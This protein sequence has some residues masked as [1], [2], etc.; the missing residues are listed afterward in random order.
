V[1][2]GVS[3][4][5]SPGLIAVTVVADADDD[6]GVDRGAEVD[7]VPED[8]S[9]AGEA[10]VLGAP[11]T[12]SVGSTDSG[13]RPCPYA[14]DASKDVIPT[15]NH[16]TLETIFTEKRSIF[17]P[18]STWFWTI[19][20]RGLDAYIRHKVGIAKAKRSFGEGENSRQTLSASRHHTCAEV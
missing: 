18:H 8:G 1:I 9:S 20:R 14:R 17:S 16:M 12:F 2:S 7:V 4:K 6:G 10:A 3:A 15:T 11:E 13:G 5:A 19:A